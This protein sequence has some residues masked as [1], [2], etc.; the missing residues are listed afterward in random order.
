MMN[1]LRRCQTAVVVMAAVVSC[2]SAAWGIQPVTVLH[3]TEADFSEGVADGTRITNTGRIELTRELTDLAEGE[4]A[5]SS[6]FDVVGPDAEGRY[7]VA[8]GPAGYFIVEEGAPPVMVGG[9][10][11]SEQVFALTKAGNR[12]IVGVSGEPS[13][14]GVEG[15]MAGEGDEEAELAVTP[16]VIL[17]GVRYIWQIVPLDGERVA[18]ATGTEGKVLIVDL[19]DPDSEPRVLLETGQSHVLSLALSEDGQTLYAGTDGEGLVYRVRDLEADKPSVYVLFDAPEPEIASMLVTRDGSLLVGTADAEQARPGRLE[20]AI[21]ESVGEVEPVLEVEPSDPIL[22]A[23]EEDEAEAEVEPETEVSADDTGD[24]VELK[25][26][27]VEP[28]QATG[29]TGE[30]RDRLREVLR[31]RLM[32]ARE[33]GEMQVGGMGQAS[34]SSEARRSA[35][36][37]RVRPARQASRDQEGNAVYAIT[38]AGFVIEVLR[39]S[40]TMLSLVELADFI[41]V[42]TGNEGQ[43]FS[44][45]EETFEVSVL[46]DFESEQVSFLRGDVGG[47][48]M[49][50]GLSNPA[51]LVSLGEGVGRR[52]TFESVAIDADQVSLWGMARVRVELPEN[53]S[54]TFETRSGNVGD[55]ESEMWSAWSAPMGL[56]PNAAAAMELPREVP[57]VSPP[58]RFL[59]YRVTLLGDG[60]VAPSVDAVELTHVTPNLPPRLASVQVQVPEVENPDDEVSSEYGIEWEASDPNG[61]RLEYVVEMQPAGSSVWIELENELAETRLSWATQRVP[62]GWYRV[63]VTADDRLDNPPDMARFARRVSD[64]VLVDQTPP[65]VE[66]LEAITMPGRAVRV[67]GEVI[68]ALSPIAGI[69]YLLDGDTSYRPIVPEDLILDSTREAFSITLRGL[70]GLERVMTLRVVDRRGNARLIPLIIRPE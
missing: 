13:R 11:E 30:Q 2:G 18:V 40:A 69:G 36:A 10:D 23:V 44:V 24:D 26:D 65:E 63:R 53:S 34:G 42:G 15:L 58:A 54:V 29:V 37:S 67:S 14:L 33:S 50:A 64:A 4:E 9:I 62:D 52:G 70:T 57:I 46:A 28:E 49:L 27:A 3:E 39:E 12:L 5:F 7:R 56:M 51:R 55:V 1:L 41:V 17:E 31:E 35:T 21:D 66:G 22:D 48:P 38:E 6:L 47:G 45:D 16:S 8:A 61:D 25:T 60:R 20:E 59:Q 32:A 68:D 43:V 19:S